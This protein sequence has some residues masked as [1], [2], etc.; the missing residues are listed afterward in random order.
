MTNER[1]RELKRPES[2][3]LNRTKRVK[4]VVE[5]KDAVIREKSQDT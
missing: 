4:D 5:K 3:E 2:K 1:E